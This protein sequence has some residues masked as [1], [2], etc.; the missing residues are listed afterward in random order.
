MGLFSF[1]FVFNCWFGLQSLCSYFFGWINCKFDAVVTSNNAI[2][3]YFLFAEKVVSS[4]SPRA[5][6]GRKNCASY[7]WFLCNMVWTV[8]LNGSGTWNGMWFNWC[9]NAWLTLALIWLLECVDFVCPWMHIWC[10]FQLWS[11]QNVCFTASTFSVVSLRDRRRQF[12]HFW[13]FNH[14]EALVL[15]NRLNFL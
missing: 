13:V 15:S 6:E 5:G 4:G 3:C 8:H 1:F 10:S 11:K 12:Y 9:G 2:A 7:Y 14:F